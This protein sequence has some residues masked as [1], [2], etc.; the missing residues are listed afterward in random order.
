M[1]DWLARVNQDLI[2]A[3]KSHETVRVS[4]LRMVKSDLNKV[5]IEKGDL[6]EQD[7]LSVLKRAVSQRRDSIEAYRKAGREDLAATEAAEIAVLDAYMPKELTDEELVSLVDEAVRETGATSPRDMGKVMK[8]VIAK[9]AGAAD[10]KR[11][12]EQVEKA[13][14]R[15]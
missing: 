4:V 11:I 14:A 15:L 6:S 1:T 2:A 5:K 13:L 8:A 3:M 7:A 10:G 9:A 12:K